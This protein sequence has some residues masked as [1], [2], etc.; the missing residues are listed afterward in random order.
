MQITSDQMH[1]PHTAVHLVVQHSVNRPFFT[2]TSLIPG[3]VD[4][5]FL[6]LLHDRC[7]QQVLY[8]R[9]IIPPPHLYTKIDGLVFCCSCQTSCHRV[10]N[11]DV[12][13]SGS[14]YCI[15]VCVRMKTIER[16]DIMLHTNSETDG[17]RV[18][19]IVPCRAVSVC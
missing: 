3:D 6:F 11:I 4:S 14:V 15:S 16:D 2:N 7:Q 17:L 9:W 13:S 8:M 12:P 5:C 19:A 18:S 10:S 1:F